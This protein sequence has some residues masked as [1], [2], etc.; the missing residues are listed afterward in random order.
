[1]LNAVDRILVRHEFGLNEA[2]QDYIVNQ[3]NLSKPD[4]PLKIANALFCP[5]PTREKDRATSYE[6]EAVKKLISKI[7]R[8]E[9]GEESVKKI[10]LTQKQ[11]DKIRHNCFTMKPMDLARSIFTTIDVK[12]LSLETRVITRL[13][14]AFQAEVAKE[15]GGENLE[16]VT[17]D[18]ENYDDEAHDFLI[19]KD[20]SPPK[21]D[22]AIIYKINKYCPVQYDKDKLTAQQRKNVDALRGYLST[23]RFIVTIN[24]IKDPVL[25][26][27]FESEFLLSAF[28]KHDLNSEE[29]NL[30]INLCRDYV[31]MADVQ[32][33][34]ATLNSLIDQQA[35][36]A[37]DDEGGI[38]LKMSLVE[39][40]SSKVNELSQTANRIQKLSESISDKRSTRIKTMT[41][42]NNSL[43]KLVEVAKSEEGRKRL[44]VIAESRNLEIEGEF[45]K[46]E[47][48]PEFVSNLFGVGRNE[49][50]NN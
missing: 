41:A 19:T 21:A 40:Y 31:L 34:L 3:C 27:L 50:V 46:I 1:M 12:P 29:C 26:V 49:I 4:S 20:Y 9:S 7:K 15:N 24:L 45:D 16:E 18:E 43:T 25:R 13:M 11:L 23:Q 5:V 36:S 42:N 32:K 47:T 44:L 2:Q 14:E 30:I 6:L 8:E 33:Q 48:A 28:D 38:K 10:D 39:M 37:D 35:D 22:G 17:I